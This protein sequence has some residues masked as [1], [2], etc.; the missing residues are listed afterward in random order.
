MQAQHE[1][2]LHE[3]LPPYLANLGLLSEPFADAP[4]G[5]FFYVGADGEQRL[6]LMHHLAPYSPL[7]VIIGE[8]GVG[9]TALL[10][11]FMARAK[12]NWRITV[13][14]AQI[15]MDRDDFMANMSE[16]LGLPSQSQIDPQA[17]YLALIAQ[18]RA[19]RHTAQVPILLID[20]A[21][22]LSV[23][24]LELI[25]KLCSEN[26]DGHILSVILFGTPQLQ[27]LWAKPSLMPLAA[28]I[29]HTFEVTPYTEEE[30]A[31][32]IRH[33]LR[34]AGASDDGPFDSVAINKIHA[35][36]G[37]IPSRINELA[38]QVLMDRSMGSARRQTSSVQ[39]GAKG[40]DR[41]RWALL[42]AGVV[43]LVLLVAGPLRSVLFESSP[44]PPPDAQQT[45]GLSL[46]P[47]APQQAGS[48]EEQVVRSGGMEAAPA[49]VPTPPTAPPANEAPP[50]SPDASGVVKT[51]PLPPEG[52]TTVSE[53]ALAEPV[54]APEKPAQP[55][56]AAPAA[57]PKTQVAV[58]PTVPPQLPAKKSEAAQTIKRSVDGSGW[59]KAQADS[60]F[61]LQLMAVKDENT[62]RQFIE[63]HQLYDKAAYFPV[64]RNG[65]TLYAVVYGS[66]SQRREA[67]QAAKSLPVAWGSPSPWIRSFKSLHGV[68]P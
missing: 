31:R 68:N 51:I 22:N 27:S 63:A 35:A 3:E 23:S 4:S 56:A 38:Q 21:Q 42:L 44:Q 25:H 65:Q 60:N 15:D 43:V 46:P 28:R 57:P 66:F 11:Q 53:S 47:S 67:A 10:Q 19:L 40:A 34:A 61:T 17:Q 29:T 14:T 1:N 59:L 9:K 62:A 37:G 41:R 12:D 2:L 58:K 24:L 5:H 16:S 50:S 39:G 6:D 48:E 64:T 13:V 45:R 54:P 26:D 18:L 52:S 36:S 8:L 7:L 33:R 30:T 49:E 32:Y 55:S 20:D